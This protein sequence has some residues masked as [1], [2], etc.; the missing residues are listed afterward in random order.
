[1]SKNAQKKSYL[2]NELPNEAMIYI[3]KYV[4]HPMNL[5]ISFARAIIT[6]EGIFSR[7]F[8]QRLLIHYSE[9]DQKLIELKISHGIRQTVVDRIKS[10]Q[11]NVLWASNDMELFHFLSGDPHTIN[12]APAILKKYRG[13]QE[14][15]IA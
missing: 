12:Y 7:Y 6:K 10:L 5:S 11:K 3:F 1:M 15:D 8:A 14:F 4:K 9:Y 2:Q 13:Y